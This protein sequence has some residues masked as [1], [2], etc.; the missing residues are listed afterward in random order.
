[1]AYTRVTR[2]A[3]GRGALEY[4]A[5]HGVGHNGKEQRNAFVGYVNLLPGIDPADQ[6]QLY[7]NK[8]R[9]NHTTQVLRIVQSFSV[10]EFDP[11]KEGDILQANE[12][13]QEF[14]K[15]YYP[16][17]QA[18]VFTQIDGKSGLVH[19]HVI[20]SDTD[21]TSS[22]GCEKEQ[23]HFPKVKEW[24]NEIFGK[25][26]ELDFG[27]QQ[28]EDKTTQTERHKREVG[29]YV[30]KD[31]LKE[32][33]TEAMDASYSEE[34]WIGTLPRYGVNIEVHDSKRRD[35]YYTYEL[36]DT[37]RFPER[38]KIPANL[39][40]RS[41]KLGTRYDS[42]GVQRYFAEKEPAVQDDDIS[43][44]M[45]RTQSHTRE[46]PE[47]EKKVK[48]SSV[49]DSVDDEPVVKRKVRRPEQKPKP[50]PQPQPRPKKTTRPYI[51]DYTPMPGVDGI[52]DMTDVLEEED[53][54]TEEKEKLAMALQAK[55]DK[56]AGRLRRKKD[57]R[58]TTVRSDAERIYGKANRRRVV[59]RIREVQK[60][61]DLE[62]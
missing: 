59:D 9:R 35:R 58:L 32:R 31:D 60:D 15:T 57:A 55:Q 24:T 4:A 13:G 56:E 30:W 19:N 52:D 43:M 17:R 47:I 16:N 7:W 53:D 28:T 51:P 14:A 29:E 6:M 49:Y 36:M 25:Y 12:I 34:Q 26:I 2:T 50:K 54:W 61:D 10:K 45:S 46:E 11:S 37:S 44:E 41:Y 18:V 8:A 23:Y 62:F 39:K 3:N 48:E 42:E 38:K 20:V 22:K 33:I 40:A 27:E 21:M 5:G 1:M